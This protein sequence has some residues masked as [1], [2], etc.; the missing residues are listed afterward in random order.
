MYRVL[1]L[2]LSEAADEKQRAC[3]TA[4][5]IHVP[6]S[7]ASTS[8]L[9]EAPGSCCFA[10]PSPAGRNDLTLAGDP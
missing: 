3:S 1:S 7:R 5:E 10:M 6:V 8:S 9:P 2:F 4:T